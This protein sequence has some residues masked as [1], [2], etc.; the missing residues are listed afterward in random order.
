MATETQIEQLSLK[1]LAK[2]EKRS[3]AEILSHLSET[4]IMNLH[5]EIIE[6]LCNREISRAVMARPIE[7]RRQ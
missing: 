6:A 2:G 7:Y 4:T 1:I 5:V 3:I